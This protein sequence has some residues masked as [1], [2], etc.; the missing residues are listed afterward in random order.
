MK[1]DITKKKPFQCLTYD[2]YVPTSSTNFQT[3]FQAC[4]KILLK[5]QYLFQQLHNNKKTIVYKYMTL[6]L[7]VL[8][9]HGHFQGGGY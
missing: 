5:S 3:Y 6:L 4:K 8:A 7:H 9:Y 1:H 2:D